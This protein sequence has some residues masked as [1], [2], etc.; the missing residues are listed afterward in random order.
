M[1]TTKRGRALADARSLA[2]Y[3]PRKQSQPG[4]DYPRSLSTTTPCPPRAACPN[5]DRVVIAVHRL[6]NHAPFPRRPMDPRRAAHR[7]PRRLPPV[8]A[9][10]RSAE[11]KKR[12]RGGIADSGPPPQLAR[13]Q[14]SPPT[15]P[16]R[17]AR[18]SA[19]RQHGRRGSRRRLPQSAATQSAHQR[20]RSPTQSLPGRQSLTSRPGQLLPSPHRYPLVSCADYLLRSQLRR[21][22]REA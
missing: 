2:L 13:T 20:V 6:K 1:E 22:R 21:L 7:S 19:S 10:E 8:T 3:C 15:A 17:L 16:R 18:T 11:A 9:L 4:P 12:R 14:R 5:S